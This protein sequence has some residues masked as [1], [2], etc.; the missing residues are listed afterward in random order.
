MR[1]NRRCYG[2]YYVDI[3]TSKY[4][5][6]SINADIQALNVEAEGNDFFADSLMNARRYITPEDQDKFMKAITKDAIINALADEPIF[7][8]TY[9]QILKNK[10]TYVTMKCMRINS[11]SSHILIAVSNIDSQIRKEY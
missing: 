6:Y 4:I 2:I 1:Q 9:R 5:Q 11:D 3:N 8:L 7:R 10:P